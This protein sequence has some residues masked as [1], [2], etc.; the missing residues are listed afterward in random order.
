MTAV[1]VGLAVVLTV[2]VVATLSH[3]YYLCCYPYVRDRVPRMSP[4]Q[5]PPLEALPV[6]SATAPPA[7]A[8]QFVAAVV[9][10][11][12]RESNVRAIRE[13]WGRALDGRLLFAVD[14]DDGEPGVEVNVQ[15]GRRLEDVVHRETKLWQ[16]V[17]M[18]KT[19][20]TTLS[21]DIAWALAQPRYLWAFQELYARFPQAEWYGVF[22]SDAYVY[23]PRLVQGLLARH[24]P[25][26]PLGLG[27]TFAGRPI[28]KMGEVISMI[29]GA[30]QILSR[31]AMERVNLTACEA[32]AMESGDYNQLS[33]SWRLAV[34]LKQRGVPVLTVET[35]YQSNDQNNCRPLGPKDCRSYLRRIHPLGVSPCALSLHYITVERMAQLYAEE[36]A[37]PFCYPVDPSN[38]AQGCH[39]DNARAQQ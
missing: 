18:N 12:G 34:C 35:M 32:R 5:A 17:T 27:R 28:K 7:P 14:Y 16:R 22:D 39:C 9:A 6:S 3:L 15:R 29:G 11:R 2:A 25:R 8:P 19:F 10:G 20:D 36:Q 30:G 33:A 37:A 24:D 26:E 13:T 23:V 1:R 4:D 31:G 21:K 38:Q